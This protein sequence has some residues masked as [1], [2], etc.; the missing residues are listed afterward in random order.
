MAAEGTPPLLYYVLFPAPHLGMGPG[1]KAG[2]RLEEQCGRV[3]PGGGEVG[4][5]EVGQTR[6]Q[7]KRERFREGFSASDR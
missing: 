6:K 2:P 1:P 5:D 7:G 4:E 3:P